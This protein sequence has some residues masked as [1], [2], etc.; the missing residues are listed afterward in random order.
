M[1]GTAMAVSFLPLL[2][3]PPSLG[4]TPSRA[5]G[6]ALAAAGLLVKGPPMASGLAAARLTVAG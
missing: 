6:G 2:N 4:G 3:P 1:T 5:A